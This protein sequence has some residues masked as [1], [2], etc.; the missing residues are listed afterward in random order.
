[1]ERFDQR[2]PVGAPTRCS[3]RRSFLDHC[4]EVALAASVGTSA[5]PP[6]VWALKKKAPPRA[7][8][9]CSGSRC[10]CSGPPI[11]SVAHK[12]AGHS[13]KWPLRGGAG[14]VCTVS[15]VC[16]FVDFYCPIP[17]FR[18]PTG[19]LVGASYRRFRLPACSHIPAVAKAISERTKVALGQLGATGNGKRRRWRGHWRGCRGARPC[20]AR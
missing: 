20:G 15:E 6:A 14:P 19:P 9:G 2:L 1:M 17:Q 13:R 4:P 11:A 18:P 12:T 8:P 7:R 16:R 5:Q 3:A 10:G